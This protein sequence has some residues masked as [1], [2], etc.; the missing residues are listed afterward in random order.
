[1]QLQGQTKTHR[2]VRS[3]GKNRSA[4]GRRGEPC[5]EDFLIGLTLS[6]AYPHLT[7]P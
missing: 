6:V 4:T 1:L 3:P 7:G 5:G 2:P